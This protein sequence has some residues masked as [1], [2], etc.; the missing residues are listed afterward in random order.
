MSVRFFGAT[1]NNPN[2]GN[3]NKAYDIG[4]IGLA[5]YEID[6]PQKFDLYHS[7]AL[8]NTW[9][10]RNIFEPYFS[11]IDKVRLLLEEVWPAGA[12]LEMLYGKKCFVGICRVMEPSVELLA[13]NDRLD[14]DSPDSL[15][16]RS[17]VS[18]LS[19]C[20]YIQVP[21]E[22]GGLRLWMKEPRNEEEYLKLCS[23]N[24]GIELHKLGQPIHVIEPKC[25]DLIIF[26]IRKYH[27]VAPAK[28]KA[29]I[30]V[31]AFIGYRSIHQ[32][33]TYWS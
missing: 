32:P 29:R 11:P 15:Q 27:G 30:N 25:G 14:R 33:L 24:Y 16:A 20:V 31:G 7:E 9:Q 4:K 21:D 3:F 1:S 12:Q 6:S 28:G 2:K 26:N 23:G 8:E 18:Q 17:L 10:L 13:H 19:A 22:G 5:H